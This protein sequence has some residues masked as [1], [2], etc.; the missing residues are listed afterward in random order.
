MGLSCSDQYIV[1]CVIC[2]GGILGRDI[3]CWISGGQDR[4]SVSI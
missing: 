1:H 2:E 3:L 4:W